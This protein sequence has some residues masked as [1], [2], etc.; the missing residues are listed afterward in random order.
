[1]AGKFEQANQAVVEA[2]YY[3][4]TEQPLVANDATPATGADGIPVRTSRGLLGIGGE[5]AFR[6]WVWVG[7]QWWRV[8]EL[9]TDVDADGDILK[10]NI[11]GAQRLYLQ[12]PAATPAV[13]YGAR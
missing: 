8:A 12:G 2:A 10:I 1:M 13:F 4:T 5:G 6:V 9:D 3:Q 11:G 7:S